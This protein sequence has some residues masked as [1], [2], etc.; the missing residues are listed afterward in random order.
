[1]TSK[2]AV[3][4]LL[5]RNTYQSLARNLLIRRKSC[6]TLQLKSLELTRK[7]TFTRSLWT[8]RPQTSSGVLIRL[9][10]RL[11]TEL[12]LK[13]LKD[14]STRLIRTSQVLVLSESRLEK[15]PWRRSLACLKEN[16]RQRCIQF[17]GIQ[18]FLEELLLIISL[19]WRMLRRESVLR[20][21]WRRL[22]MRRGRRWES[23]LSMC[24][25][26]SDLLLRMNFGNND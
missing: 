3:I 23:I 10:M 19:E 14:S 24:L 25:S 18:G 2:E 22:M 16:N 15:K 8:L 6:M 21:V 1:M 9:T 4:S 7:K 12:D 11:W 17:Q 13:N 26:G 5:Q 20:R